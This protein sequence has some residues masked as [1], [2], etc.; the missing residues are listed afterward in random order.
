MIPNA[1]RVASHQR[2]LP[3]ASASASSPPTTIV[4]I[5]TVRA[6][7]G[8]SSQPKVPII[9]W[10]HSGLRPMAARMA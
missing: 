3:R 1:T 9:S 7:D 8:V 2:R 10:Y 6:G 5:T 4:Q